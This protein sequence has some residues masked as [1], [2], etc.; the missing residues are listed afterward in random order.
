MGRFER[1]DG[2]RESRGRP[3]DRRGNSL[4][5]RF[6]RTFSNTSF[7]TAAVLA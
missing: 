5:Y 4:P 7:A 2:L 6:G 3:G 1:W